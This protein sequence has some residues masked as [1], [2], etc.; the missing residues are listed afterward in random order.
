MKCP[1]C[2]AQAYRRWGVHF[3]HEFMCSQQ[4]CREV[5]DPEDIEDIN[6][7]KGVSE[8]AKG[9]RINLIPQA[10]DFEER[11]GS[12]VYWA[13]NSDPNLP[14]LSPETGECRKKPPI[15]MLVP[16]NLSAHISCVARMEDGVVMLAVFPPV[17]CFEWC[18]SYI[19]DPY[20]AV[21]LANIQ[22]NCKKALTT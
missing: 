14:N 8:M 4:G 18:G 10:K 16:G 13:Q 15:A 6:Q 17:T 21:K 1:F 11:C 2:G 12:C 9:G 5:F 20:A 3:D 7:R 19:K 22:D